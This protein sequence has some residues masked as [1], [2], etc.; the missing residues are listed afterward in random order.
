MATAGPLSSELVDRVLVSFE[1]LHRGS[2][3]QL[4]VVDDGKLFVT[5]G[6]DGIVCIWRVRKS[7]DSWRLEQEASN[8]GH[9]AGSAITSLRVSKEQGLVV[10]GSDDCTVSVWDLG[11]RQELIRDLRGHTK[12]IRFVG[13]NDLNGNIMSICEREVRMWHVNGDLIAAT[14][15]KTHN[16]STPTAAICTPCYSY[17]PGIV[18][19]IGHTN[20]DISL[21]DFLYPGDQ[22]LQPRTNNA[23]SLEL[24]AILKHGA[25]PI[26]ALKLSRDKRM[27]VSGDLK[28][29]VRRWTSVETIQRRYRH[30]T[31][32]AS[33][34]NLLP[35][36][37]L[38]SSIVGRNSA[39]RGNSDRSLMDSRTPP[40]SFLSERTMTDVKGSSLLSTSERVILDSKNMS[41]SKSE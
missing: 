33:G 18:I 37:L 21:W 39:L 26:I 10:S 25:S 7:R 6:T 13:V 1:H 8:V 2:I 3:T 15:F 11:R 9:R 17:Q 19:V 23:T 41:S 28:G 4:C 24:R 30:L 38:V 12:P 31:G 22:S 5:G 16:L 34:L 29:E 32:Q 35:G 36:Q 14:E 27:L 20:G 40:I